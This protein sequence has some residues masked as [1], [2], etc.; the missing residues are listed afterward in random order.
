MFVGGIALAVMACGAAMQQFGSQ[1]LIYIGMTVHWYGGWVL[2]VAF[3]LM[4]WAAKTPVDAGVHDAWR[5]IDLSQPALVE[6]PLNRLSSG[7]LKNSR[8]RLVRLGNI[9]FDESVLHDLISIMPIEELD[10]RQVDATPAML[11]RLE[12][13]NQVNIMRLRSGVLAPRQLRSLQIALPACRILVDDGLPADLYGTVHAH[14]FRN[15]PSNLAKARELLI[16][17][18]PKQPL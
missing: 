17:M 8:W 14:E 4:F 7:R 11:E 6:F 12:V 5:S 13:L 3:M 18:M 10:L 2:F 15:D 9:Q 1:E 16:P